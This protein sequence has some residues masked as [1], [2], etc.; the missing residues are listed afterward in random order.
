MLYEEA[1][2]KLAWEA[3]KNIAPRLRTLAADEQDRMSHMLFAWWRRCAKTFN[4]GKRPERSSRCR[5]T[6]ANHPGAWFSGTG[7]HRCRRSG[8]FRG[9]IVVQAL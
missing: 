7:W 5:Q 1:E 8:A 6:F 2:E 3:Y 9:G 4:I